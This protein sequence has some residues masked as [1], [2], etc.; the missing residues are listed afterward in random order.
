MRY[1][2]AMQ[3]PYNIAQVWDPYFINSMIQV[4]VE[5]LEVKDSYLQGHTRQV[6]EISLAIGSRMNLSP[7]EL[8]DLYAGAIL[9]DIGKSVGTTEATL[10]KPRSLDQ[11]EELIM[12]EH[13][14]K[15]GLLI[16]GLEN[17]SHILPTIMHHHENW[18]GTGYPDR[19]RDESIPLHARIICVADAFDAMVSPRSFRPAMSRE[20]AI[21]ELVK[22]KEKQFDPDIV[23]TLIVCLEDNPHEFKDF[24]YYF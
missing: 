21:E 23:D 1:T 4:L 13:P 8:R 18:D 22:K 16:V 24:S 20:E 2:D 12:R 14:L 6:V 17:L 5:A 3:K 10:N 9:H 11:R 7:I 19:L 15:A